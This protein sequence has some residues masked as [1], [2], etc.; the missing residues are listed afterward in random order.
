MLLNLVYGMLETISNAIYTTVA[1][2][3]S[4]ERK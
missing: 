4:I 1:T 2:V 3:W